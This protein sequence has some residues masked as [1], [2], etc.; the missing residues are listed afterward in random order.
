MKINMDELLNSMLEGISNMD[1]VRSEDIPNIEII[2][3]S[4]DQLLW[5]K[6]LSSSKRYDK[7]KILTKTMINNYAKNN[8]LPTTG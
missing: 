4:G 8:L 2:Y 7:D 6:Q 5:T 1:Y 3:G